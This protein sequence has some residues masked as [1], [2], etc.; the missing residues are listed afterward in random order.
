LYK[1][2]LKLGAFVYAILLVLSL[3]FFEERTAFLDIAY[4]LFYIIKDG[5]FAIQNNRFG[6]CFTQVFPLIAS[7][8]NL[9]LRLVMKVYSAA[10]VV[11]YASVFFVMMFVVKSYQFSLVMLLHCTLMVTD[12][13]F[14]IQSELPQGLAFLLLFFSFIIHKKEFASSIWYL[15]FITIGMLTVTFFHP[16]ILF[17]FLFIVAFF[18]TKENLQLKSILVSLAITFFGI[19][20]LK[21]LFFKTTYDS[22]AIGGL[23]NFISF[24][25]DYITLQSNKDFIKYVLA[26]Y[27]I[28][29]LLFFALLFFYW[30]F[31]KVYKFF[32]LFTFVTGYLLIVNVSFSNGAEQFYMENLYLPLSVMIIISFV[33]DLMPSVQQKYVVP[34]LCFI[35]VVRLFQISIN[36]QPYT[37][38]LSYLKQILDK[39]ELLENKKIIIPSSAVSTDTLMM[40]WASP[41]EFWLL[42]TTRA[43][44]TRSVFISDSPDEIS[45]AL[46][47][48]K[49][50]ITK[51][52]AFDYHALPIQYF[53]LNDTVPYTIIK[54]F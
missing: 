28:I 45:W 14:W 34:I 35:L 15:P 25:P 31:K 6:S 27:Q 3:F 17:P 51:W 48:R 19:I 38:R 50:F 16:L 54:N 4:H 9:D 52:G 10:F 32:L 24:F 33:F 37:E 1:N 18:Y 43:N 49:K 29:W 11:V 44:R 47:Y 2:V 30:R 13:F 20:I 39:T 23:K 40:T 36:H 26:D 8:L 12:T 22:A 5:D 42:S 46:S 41:Y 21:Q 7:K 53:V